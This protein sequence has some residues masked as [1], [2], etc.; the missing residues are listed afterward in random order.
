[1]TQEEIIFM[2]DYDIKDMSYYCANDE[3]FEA[4]FTTNQGEEFLFTASRAKVMEHVER[5]A[6]HQ[7]LY[8][9]NKNLVVSHFHYMAME[10][11]AKTHLPKSLAK[12]L[13]KQG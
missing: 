5:F 4:R 11:Y 12:E 13:N 3:C 6:S 9:T 7:E 1:M 2:R 10:W 8:V